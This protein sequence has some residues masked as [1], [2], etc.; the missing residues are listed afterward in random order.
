[1]YILKNHVYKL[2]KAFTYKLTEKEFTLQRQE[3]NKHRIRNKNRNTEQEQQNNQNRS[4]IFEI[5]NPELKPR[6]CGGRGN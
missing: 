4:T 6:V 5:K 2:Q 3:N 1:V